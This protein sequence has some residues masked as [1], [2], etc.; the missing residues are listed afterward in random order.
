MCSR[1]RRACRRLEGE[2]ESTVRPVP[3]VVRCVHAQNAF[4]MS[5]SEDEDAI[6]AVAADGAHPALC[7]RVCV[8]RLNGCLD[9][10]DLL[11]AEDLVEGRA[12]L[13]I[14]VMDQQPQPPLVV[15]EL[16]D[17]VAGLLGHPGAV[18]I[19]RAGEIRCSAS[20]S[21][22]KKS[23]ASVLAA[24]WRRNERHDWRAR[25]GA[26]GTPWRLRILRIVV[27]EAASPRCLSSPA[28][29]G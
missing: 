1:C 17:E 29:R 24:C 4:E 2:P 23:L 3:V 27:G 18:G 13:R 8:W 25:S 7:V 9:H 10:L 6:E 28:I 11:G 15:A 14:A 22:V 26:G 21:T 16:D 20:V 12:E 19:G 5:A